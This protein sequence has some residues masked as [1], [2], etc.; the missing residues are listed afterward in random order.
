M[1]KI[2]DALRKIQAGENAARAVS[3]DE[4]ER[5]TRLAELAENPDVAGDASKSKKAVKANKGRIVKI[6]HMALREA[7][8]L[9]PQDDERLLADEY[10]QI[11]RPIIANAA[12]NNAR[13]N[14]QG[15]AVMIG[16]ALSGDGKSF[17]AINLALS[18]AREKDLSVLLVDADVVKPQISR[19][20]GLEEEEGLLDYLRDPRKNLDDVIFKS[21]VDGLELLAAGTQRNDSTELLASNAMNALLKKLEEQNRKRLILF[22]SSPL[23]QTTESRALADKVGQIVIVIKANVTPI[24]SVREVVRILEDDVAVNMVLNEVRQGRRQNYYGSYYGTQTN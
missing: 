24:N 11:K 13:D 18:I 15:L 23:L 8:L 1:S 2:M 17:T 12:G 19:L 20:F 22:D 9:C 4:T 3:I 16:S 6:N 14:P 5:R 21:D 7:G 10:R